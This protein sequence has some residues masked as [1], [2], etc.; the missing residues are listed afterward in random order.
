MLTIFE[1]IAPVFLLILLGFGFKRRGFPGDGF[2]RPAEALAYYVL[3]PALIVRNLAAAELGELQ[4]ATL[5]LTIVS[6]ALVMT[7]L[8][9]ALSRLLKISGAVFTSVLQGSIRLNAYIAFAV[10]AAFRGPPGVAL[11]AVFAAIMM[12]TVNLISITALAASVGHDRLRWRDMAWQIVTNPLILACLL[13]GALNG[14]STELPGWGT[15]LLKILGNAALPIA[16]FAVGA[17]LDLAV[18]RTQA[19]AVAVTC[20][21]KLIAMP[22]IAYGLA[23]AFGLGPLAFMIVVLFAATPGSPA[24]YVLARQLGGDAPLMAGIL[25]AETIFTAVTLPVVLALSL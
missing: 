24:S 14:S 4:L 23:T 13:G 21:L 1:T 7:G 20:L 12:P 8:T 15:V 10:A 5:A 2:W 9:I 25:T 19:G 11:V 6:L 18:G 16:L 22:A 3:L 17:G